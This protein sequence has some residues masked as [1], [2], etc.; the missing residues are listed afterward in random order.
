MTPALK[1]SKAERA[2]AI[3]QAF[4]DGQVPKDGVSD[5]CV[6]R[7]EIIESYRQLLDDITKGRAAMKFIRG[8]YG[9]GKSML[10]EV[11]EQIARKKRFAVAKVSIRSELPFNKIE[12]LYRKITR[13][14]VTAGGGEGIEG[15][16]RGWHNYLRKKVEKNG[17]SDD[18]FEFNQKIVS[19][20]RKHL[21]KV[22]AASPAFA[23]GVEAYLLGVQTNDLDKANAA[24]TWLRQDPSQRAEDKRRIG[25]KGNLTKE[26]ATEFLRAF[27]C[28][29]RWVPL[30]GTVILVDEVEYMRN[31][32]QARLRTAAYDNIRALWDA[33][34][35]GEIEYTLFVFAATDEMF[36]DERKGFPSYAAL[37]DRMGL[38]G[39][40]IL[41]NPDMHWPVVDLPL[42]TVKQAV[43]LSQRLL[44]LYSI[45]EGWDGKAHIRGELLEQVAEQAAVGLLGGGIRPREFVR[46]TIRWFDKVKCSPER[47]MEDYLAMFGDTFDKAMGEEDE[48]EPLWGN[49]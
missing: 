39:G 21:S 20:G 22:R 13:E 34:N 3:L 49:L 7:E 30:A 5:L 4:R 17:T 36:E 2:R 43:E 10:L 26:M 28:F 35:N 38:D 12:E 41:E 33:C 40:Q 45:A 9:Y 42:L 48:E 8:N 47:S 19:M 14:V 24:I 31:L 11:F 18:P 15:L 44:R 32:S 23:Q 6:G 37:S 46:S 25:V 27:L 1:T 16:L 29:V